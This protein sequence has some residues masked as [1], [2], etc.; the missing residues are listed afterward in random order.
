MGQF[1]ATLHAKG[2]LFNDAQ[3][4]VR[5]KRKF[6]YDKPEHGEAETSETGFKLIG[7]NEKFS[8][9]EAQLYTGRMHQIRATLYSLGFP[10]VGDKLY[11]VDD[12]V[13]LRFAQKM[14]SDTDREKM[15]LDRQALHSWQLKFKHPV[16]REIIALKAAV[17]DDIAIFL[18]EIMP[19][20][21]TFLQ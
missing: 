8:L 11:G 12:S 7:S 21:V 14:M 5:K 17:T 6:A 2:F 10:L 1:P 16:S 9:V 4:E 20:F 18:K 15:L 13:Y 3:S 19:E